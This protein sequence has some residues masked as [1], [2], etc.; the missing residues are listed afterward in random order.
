MLGVQDLSCFFLSC[1]IQR[2][3][4]E[5]IELIVVVWKILVFF[6]YCIWNSETGNGKEGIRA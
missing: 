5:R 6:Y 3:W 1:E 2:D 4:E